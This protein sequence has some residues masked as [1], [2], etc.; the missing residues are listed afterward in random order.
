[1]N[2]YLICVIPACSTARRL[3]HRGCY[4]NRRSFVQVNF[5][6]K[7]NRLLLF[8]PGHTEEN[9]IKIYNKN[10][11]CVKL[12]L[13]AP[14]QIFKLLLSKHKTG[15]SKHPPNRDKICRLKAIEIVR[16]HPVG[17]FS[18]GS[19]IHSLSFPTFNIQIS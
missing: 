6:E 5:T 14:G 1:V 7:T 17:K 16:G 3:N 12:Q 9:Y 2:Y 10:I 8:I 13:R 19:A 15:N 4:I 11:E 18:V